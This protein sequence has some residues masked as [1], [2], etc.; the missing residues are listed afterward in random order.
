MAK[1]FRLFVAFI[2]VAVAIGMALPVATASQPT[3]A[4][5]RLSP[6]AAR[7]ATFLILAPNRTLDYGGYI[8]MELSAE[9]FARLQAS[10]ISYIEEPNAGRVHLPNYQ[11][12]PLREGEPTV[13]GALTATTGSEPTLV[14]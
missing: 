2:V 10:G 1:Y 11:F 5:V 8:W 6:E 9:A 14:I 3:A 4:V 7:Q 12:D 13:P